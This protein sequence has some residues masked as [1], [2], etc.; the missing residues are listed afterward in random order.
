[1]AMGFRLFL[2]VAFA[3]SYDGHLFFGN[4]KVGVPY[5]VCMWFTL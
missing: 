4:E 2:M 1:L 3:H 5:D